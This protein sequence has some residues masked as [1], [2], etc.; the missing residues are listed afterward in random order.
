MNDIAN[1]WAD[2]FRVGRS[3]LFLLI[4]LS[5]P[6]LAQSQS[7]ADPE[8][9]TFAM[10]INLDD[11]V[12]TAQYAPTNSKNALQNIRTI[13]RKTIDRQ[14]ANNLEQLLQQDLNIRISQD[15]V[16]GSSMSL[17]GV[18]GENIKIM[19][20]GIPVV[21]RLNGN[22]DL[23]QINLQNI[24]RVEIVEGPMSV[25]YGTD[26]LGGAI[27]LITQKS[28][29]SPFQLSIGQ[30]LE[31]NAE[32]STTVNS[33]ARL[34]DNWLLKLNGGRDWFNGF[35]ED[36][37]RSV[38]WNP[39]EQ[40]Y[41]DGSVRH[42]FGEDHRLI[43]R[44]S[45]FDE[46]VQN[47]GDVRRPQFQP[48]AFDDYFLTKR[49]DNALLH[50]GTVMKHFYWQNT[51]G[52]NYF[53]RQVNSYRLDFDSGRQEQ[54]AG[55]G[56]TTVF[57]TFMAR[58]VLASRLP[59]SKVNFQ[60][61]V[62]TE[63]ETGSG[64]RIIDP[65]SDKIGESTIR[66]FA[67]FGSL[68]FQPFEALVLETGLRLPY[69]SRYDAPL[70]PSFHAKYQLAEEVSMRA[71]YGK[72]FRSPSLKELFLS[73]IDINHYIVGNP[74]LR[75][76]TSD[77]LQLN[78]AYDKEWDKQQFGAKINFFHNH[79]QDQIQLFPFT[80]EGGEILPSTP[81]VSTQYAY[82]NLDRSKTQGI[83]SQF[84][85]QWRNLSLEGGLSWIGFYNPLSQSKDIDRFTYST[86]LSGKLGYRLSATGTR[87]NL[88]V[89]KNDRLISYYPALE[90]GVEVARQRL[91]DGFTLLDG[92]VS[93]SFFDQQLEL[94]AGVRN[95][96]DVTQVNIT[97]GGGGA[98][99][100]GNSMPVGAGRSFFVRARFHVFK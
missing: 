18:S 34:G 11:V 100:G 56:D 13:D 87:F 26:A 51:I 88:F 78:I 79:I 57:N 46:E 45:F 42:D 15:M 33:G 6:L 4:L 35:G 62:D 61:G 29:L 67:V 3:F 20:D 70:V 59:N 32:S 95:I 74:D 21:G 73:F 86:E 49:L 58:S 55:Q 2:L 30:Q 60:L 39:K 28:Q 43:Y 90:D 81:D 52:H 71:S 93:H 47:L 19:I 69:N 77:N 37:T 31:T 16:L 9:D 23:S 10:S 5:F 12:V 82:F 22:I 40:W 50:E 1:R 92:S 17:L 48:Y 94:F 65:E 97:G 80:N 41:F 63:I 68:R 91:Q 76:E 98:H 85:Y 84:S 96:L 44:F 89:R 72:G 64:A 7:Y 99:S 66:D 38:L 8:P 54:I 83:N 14:G 75:A 24:A 53:D 25:T 27:N 36:T